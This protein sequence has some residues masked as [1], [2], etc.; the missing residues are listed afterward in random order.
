MG[1]RVERGLRHADHRDAELS[2]RVRTQAGT[3][4]GVKVSV[5]VDHQENQPA[6]D[7][8]DRREFTQ[9]ELTKPVRQRLRHDF[10][11]SSH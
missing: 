5:T 8:A 7:R 10:R 3:A 4:A 1:S 2:V 11:A 9:I 6:Q